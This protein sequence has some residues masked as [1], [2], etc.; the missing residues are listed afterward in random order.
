VV[1]YELSSSNSYAMAGRTMVH[2]INTPTKYSAIH[3]NGAGLFASYNR[4]IPKTTNTNISQ[5]NRIRINDFGGGSKSTAKTTS[6]IRKKD[7]NEFKQKRSL[8]D[9]SP[10]HEVNYKDGY[11]RKLGNRE[12]D[13]ILVKKVWK[14]TA[15]PQPDEKTDST[16]FRVRSASNSKKYRYNKDS[17]KSFSHADVILEIERAATSSPK[18]KE[19]SIKKKSKYAD[20]TLQSKKDGYGTSPSPLTIFHLGGA[21][22]Q[23]NNLNLILSSDPNYA[24]NAKNTIVSSSSKKT[25]NNTSCMVSTSSRNASITPRKL[26]SKVKGYADMGNNPSN[27]DKPHKIQRKNLRVGGNV[28]ISKKHTIP[29]TNVIRP[30]S[31]TKRSKFTPDEQLEMNSTGSNIVIDKESY[32]KIINE[33]GR[34]ELKKLGIVAQEDERHT[35]MPDVIRNRPVTNIYGSVKQSPP[36]EM[37]HYSSLKKT[38]DTGYTPHSQY[39]KQKSGV[40]NILKAKMEIRTNSDSQDNEYNLVLKNERNGLIKA[41]NGNLVF[42]PCEE[43]DAPIFPKAIEKPDTSLSLKNNNKR[44]GDVFMSH[45]QISNKFNSRNDPYQNALSDKT[46]M[47]TAS[48]KRVTSNSK[49]NSI[50]TFE[51]LND[52]TNEVSLPYRHGKRSSIFKDI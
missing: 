51:A 36:E 5:G 16:E 48:E 14:N 27:G 3:G 10:E 9:S 50:Y 8:R 18:I 1:G 28:K 7:T 22:D 41:V 12:R 34:S 33:L 24:N 2:Q 25:S 21:S 42:S 43:V 4:S 45:E 11:S 31:G 15:K 38:H 37:A 17:S 26:S 30:S 29:K 46:V 47:R 44:L 19:S 52:L 20:L 35:F 23:S 40:K 39:S 13:K 32:Q 49:L 6:K